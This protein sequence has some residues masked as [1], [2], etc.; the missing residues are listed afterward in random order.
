MP[1][2]RWSE[3]S[4]YDSLLPQE[5]IKDFSE[6]Y[7][8]ILKYIKE[9]QEQINI[10]YNIISPNILFTYIKISMKNIHAIIPFS[11]YMHRINN[12]TK[13]EMKKFEIAYILGKEFIQNDN[14][15]TEI[16]LAQICESTAKQI[17]LNNLAIETFY[18]NDEDNLIVYKK[19]NPNYFLIHTKHTLVPRKYIL[20]FIK[21]F[22]DIVIKMNGAK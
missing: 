9:S 13:N 12:I 1:I 10:K 15:L 4:M 21:D 14:D 6:S 11:A 16:D 17:A 20:D 22:S 3:L 2:L 5:Y 7:K 18:K 19:N 8:T